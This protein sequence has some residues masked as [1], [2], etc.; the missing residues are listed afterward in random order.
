MKTIKSLL[1]SYGLILKYNKKIIVKFLLY[2]LLFSLLSDVISSASYPDKYS[3]ITRIIIFVIFSLIA[4]I[5]TI[6]AFYVFQRGYLD[7]F[8]KTQGYS[9]K[10]NSFYKTLLHTIKI[11]VI[12]TLYIALISAG[13]LVSIYFIALCIFN[14][15]LDFG[16]KYDSSFIVA[17]INFCFTAWFYRLIFILNVDSV[18]N[19]S[20]ITHNI[21]TKNMNIITNNNRILLPL[22]CIN[23]LLIV[24]KNYYWL[25]ALYC[26]FDFTPI[27][28]TIN[29]C[30]T[31]IYSLII[32][33]VFTSEYLKKNK[34]QQF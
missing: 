29:F 12:Q 4:S 24:G 6:W 27:T 22:Y 28:K 20:F 31:I 2:T 1:Q 5:G 9:I 10:Y 13:I 25:L 15:K 21:I 3:S 26:G 34:E 11:N 23:L 16:N 18:E 19:D 32:V 30:F 17:I 8:S 14:Y 33:F 7:F